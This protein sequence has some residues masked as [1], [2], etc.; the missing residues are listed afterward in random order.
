MKTNESKHT[1]G[2]WKISEKIGIGRTLV[3]SNERFLGYL[4]A[5]CCVQGENEANVRLCAAA[6]E[7]LSA[8]E[9][10]ANRIGAM[11]RDYELPEECNGIIAGELD[12][13]NAAIAKAIT[14]C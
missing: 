3:D 4:D 11:M 1:P 12:A 2:P 8:C 6:P 9:D 10:M 13:V 7:L 14:K 5:A